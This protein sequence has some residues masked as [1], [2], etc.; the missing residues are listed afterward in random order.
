VT[1]VIELK[2]GS[3]LDAAEVM[4]WCKTQLGSIKAP[5]SVQIW[6]ELP[7]TSVGKVDKKAIRKRFWE[8][9]E[10]AI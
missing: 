8:G 2:A 6:A 9:S 1:G 3:T 4:A 7:R 10:R 5:K